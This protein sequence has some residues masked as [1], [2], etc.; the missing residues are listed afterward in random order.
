MKGN[1]MA[2]SKLTLGQVDPVLNACNA[3]LSH[4]GTFGARIKLREAMRSL[5]THAQDFDTERQT[6]VEKYAEK[7]EDGKPIL[8][9]AGGVQFGDSIDEVDRLWRELVATEVVVVHKLALDDVANL[10]GDPAL[11]ALELL[12]M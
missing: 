7:G 11:D 4:A 9:E 2:K 12:V 6:L 5:S 10:P 3:A 1:S 8:T